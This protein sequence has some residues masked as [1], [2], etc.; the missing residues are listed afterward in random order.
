MME[1]ADNYSFVC[2]FDPCIRGYNKK[3]LVRML[4]K[5]DASEVFRYD[6]EMKCCKP[7]ET[8]GT[9]SI[10]DLAWMTNG[11]VEMECRLMADYKDGKFIPDIEFVFYIDYDVKE[12]SKFDWEWYSEVMKDGVCTTDFSREDWEECLEKE[13]FEKMGK[14]CAFRGIPLMLPP[15]E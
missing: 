1:K 12:Y 14:Y 11:I 13:M 6:E 9:A 2:E 10:Q 8:N 4:C 3:S 15:E 7:I 5:G